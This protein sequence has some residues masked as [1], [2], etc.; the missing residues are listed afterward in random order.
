MTQQIRPELF[1][2]VTKKSKYTRFDYQRYSDS[3]PSVVP[4]GHGS[5]G[6]VEV[7]CRFLFSKSKWGHMGLDMG[8]DLAKFPAGILYLDM[9]FRQP[10]DCKLQSATVAVTLGKDEDGA[11]QEEIPISMT[12]FYGPGQLRGPRQS[13]QSKRVRQFMPHVEVL[14]YGAGGAGI[15][16]EETR[17][18]TDRWGFSGHLRCAPGSLTYNRL[19][20]DLDESFLEERP[21]HGNVFH[22][23]FAIGHN[24]KAFHM[25][26]EVKGKLARKRDQFKHTMNR[27]KFGGVRAR[28]HD[29][30][31]VKF[32]W[33]HGY[34]PSMWL[35]SIAQGLPY[36]MEEENMR[37]VPIEVPEPQPA[38]F[39]PVMNSDPTTNPTT[40]AI[41]PQRQNDEAAPATHDGTSD[42]MMFSQLQT[43]A[44]PQLTGLSRA[45]PHLTPSTPENMARAAGFELDLTSATPQQLESPLS[46]Q[47]SEI[48]SGTTLV[49]SS[50]ESES[51]EESG[52]THRMTSR[53]MCTQLERL[54]TGDCSSKGIKRKE[55]KFSNSEP[56]MKAGFI[57][58]L[59]CWLQGGLTVWDLF[60]AMLGFV[61]YPDPSAWPRDQRGSETPEVLARGEDRKI[62]APAW[63][64][65]PWLEDLDGDTAV[66]VQNGTEQ[67]FGG[68]KDEWECRY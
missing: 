10:Q 60:A 25:T 56:T 5:I 16:T 14:G 2:G 40:S 66:M 57:V 67:T 46:L 54:R 15:S 34:S 35:D 61:A 43:T 52:P 32:Q 29:T 47:R 58:G 50:Q 20:W 30:A 39:R 38:F 36:A 11:G 23:A 37:S 64:K 7:D 21:S 62:E 22:T 27:L 4:V 13:V 26:V 24:A 8:N 55:V 45:L 17:H 3:V 53:S 48:S 51:G 6:K 31:A 18:I 65:K 1:K 41:S 68:K 19:E 44:R 9:V 42:H 12:E 59:I 33:S 28:P 63:S 49:E